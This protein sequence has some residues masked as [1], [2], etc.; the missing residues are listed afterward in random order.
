MNKK[1]RMPASS[2]AIAIM[3]L[4]SCGDDDSSVMSDRE[5]VDATDPSARP[6]PTPGDD[7]KE[8]LIL[9][10]YMRFADGPLAGGSL[11]I[12]ADAEGGQAT[13][14]IEFEVARAGMIIT[15][16]CLDAETL[17][18]T[19]GFIV[20]G[21]EVTTPPD[22]G[23]YAVG[24]RLF[25]IVRRGEPTHSL[26]A[27]YANEDAMI[28]GGDAAGSCGELVDSAPA[29]LLTDESNWSTVSNGPDGPSSSRKA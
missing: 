4:S 13:G 27:M 15:L 11:L 24:E 20:W 29:D 5:S 26:G 17:T 21:G 18:G 10:G 25:V 2:A 23:T 9:P 12:E 19:G 6:I 14:T 7:G 22:D 3:L 1:L 28:A 16:D 8:D